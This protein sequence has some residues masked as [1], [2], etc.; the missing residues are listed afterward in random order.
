MPMHGMMAPDNQSDLTAAHMR[1]A[2]ARQNRRTSYAAQVPGL[3]WKCGVTKIGSA[4]ALR[5]A[6]FGPGHGTAY[7]SAVPLG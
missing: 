3:S 6:C 2:K 5:S 7:G 4:C 1:K